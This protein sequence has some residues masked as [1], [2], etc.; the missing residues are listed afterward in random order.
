[1]PK[2]ASLDS[3]LRSGNI[4]AGV[5]AGRQSDRR[6]T[7][8]TTYGSS[9]PSLDDSSGVCAALVIRWLRAKAQETDFWA[10]Q[11][12]SSSGLLPESYR[13]FTEV[14]SEHRTLGNAKAAIGRDAAYANALRGAV[15]HSRTDA[16]GT[17]AATHASSIANT[18]LTD[19]G[20]YFVLSLARTGGAHALGL[21]RPWA[22]WGKKDHAYFYDPNMGE[23]WGYKLGLQTILSKYHKYDKG[24]DL[25]I[26]T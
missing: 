23:F 2:Y 20:R 26:F 4:G 11:S 25:R 13:F 15:T 8:V 12:N 17:S 5:T 7:G 19:G 24:Y 1:M 18:V 6:R 22:L 21:F 9:T 10:P 16:S 3:Q 14:Y